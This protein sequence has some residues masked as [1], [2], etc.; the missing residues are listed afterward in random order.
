MIGIGHPISLESLI[1]KC[2]PTAND[3][4]V[5]FLMARKIQH[6]LSQQTPIPPPEGPSLCVDMS[7]V[8]VP[9][10][11]RVPL[12]DIGVP[13]GPLVSD[14]LPL[15]LRPR[16]EVLGDEDSLESLALMKHMMRLLDAYE[17]ADRANGTDP[18]APQ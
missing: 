12:A 8:W 4:L 11:D 9:P 15:L 5:A 2:F 3:Y 1:N 16:K 18:E 7:E 6:R 17:E 10:E 13:P 14:A